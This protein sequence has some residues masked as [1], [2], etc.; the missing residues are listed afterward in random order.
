[1]AK[2]TLKFGILNIEEELYYKYFSPQLVDRICKAFSK[3]TKVDTIGSPSIIE[4]VAET[5][6]VV[7]TKPG[8]LGKAPS[9]LELLDLLRE[10][11]G[12]QD[13]RFEPIE[14]IGLIVTTEHPQDQLFGYMF[15]NNRVRSPARE[16]AAIYL[17]EII[18]RR[19]AHEIEDQIVFTTVHELGHVFHLKHNN[20]SASYLRSSHISS[21]YS[22]SYFRFT[23][24]QKKHLLKCDEDPK[25]WPG[26]S[27]WIS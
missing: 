21:V 11:V 22:D 1:M 12:N 16:G 13:G 23:K 6:P 24:S 2:F 10:L 7:F 9:K 5:T 17:D 4:I 18:Y 25:V 26:G 14:N 27:P 3:A 20:V 19:P 8:S 15:D